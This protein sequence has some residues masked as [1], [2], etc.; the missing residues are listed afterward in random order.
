MTNE[1]EE[2]ARSRRNL[3]PFRREEN[4]RSFYGSGRTHVLLRWHAAGNA[5]FCTCTMSTAFG[6][7]SGAAK[8]EEGSIKGRVKETEEN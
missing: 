8:I 7:Y 3:I 2:R 5:C 6:L 4:A 1:N